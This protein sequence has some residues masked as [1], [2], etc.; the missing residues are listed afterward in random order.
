MSDQLSAGIGGDSVM[1]AEA[2]KRTSVRCATP[3]IP[4]TSR[5]VLPPRGRIATSGVA[6]GSR[7]SLQHLVVHWG[8]P[9]TDHAPLNSLRPAAARGRWRAKRKGLTGGGPS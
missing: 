7:M 8:I 4:G 9:G 6:R 1:A 3:D 5:Q 2:V